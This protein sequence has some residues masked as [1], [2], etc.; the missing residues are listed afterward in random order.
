MMSLA[1]H[2]GVKKW[3]GSPIQVVDKELYKKTKGHASRS[4][5]KGTS[6]FMEDRVEKLRQLYEQCQPEVTHKWVLPKGVT[7]GRKAIRVELIV[8]EDISPFDLPDF[9]TVMPRPEDYVFDDS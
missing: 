2:S 1:D 5:P 4:R 8:G 3:E 9:E 7:D 6:R